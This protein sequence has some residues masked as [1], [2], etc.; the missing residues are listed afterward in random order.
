MRTRIRRKML[1]GSK[2][3]SFVRLDGVMWEYQSA[4]GTKADSMLELRGGKEEKQ[5]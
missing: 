5:R 3:M 4:G 2:T 1:S